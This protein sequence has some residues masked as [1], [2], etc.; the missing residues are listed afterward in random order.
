MQFEFT[1]GGHLLKLKRKVM[2]KYVDPAK[3][4]IYQPVEVTPPITANIASPVYVFSGKQQKVVQVKLK[5]FVEGSGSIS[6]KPLAG[7]NISPAKISFTNKKKN[8]EWT[9]EFV[10]SPTDNQQKVSELTAV[11]EIN[12]KASSMGLLRI[13]YD[14]IPNITLFPPAQA[15]LVN[16]DL[17][18][19]AGGKKIGYI[20]G[21][22]DL[23]PDALRQIGYDVHML[24]ENEVMNTDLS[25]YSAIITGVRTYNVNP[26]MVVEQPRLLEYVKNGGNLVVQYNTFNN[27]VKTQ[28]GP[29]PFRVVN[30][31]VTD[32]TAKV[33]FTNPNSTI[34]N[35]PN[36]ITQADFD[37]WIQERGLY[38][39]SGIDPNYQTLFEMND[40]GEAP[41]K[42]SLIYTD[43]GNGRFVYTSLDF[44]RE[45][46]AGVPGAY[47]LFINLMSAPPKQVKINK[48][49]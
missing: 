24:T 34:L 6:L 30:E 27:L 8:E 5:S 26:R 22:G 17:N 31:R 7:W 40:P 23:V 39:V 44:F 41:N 49:K 12:G 42:G 28:I 47:R 15:K 18:I 45:L 20:A 13:H 1:I 10:V 32:E 36:K 21:A 37:G 11:A 19:A 33:T 4:E 35:F 9:A 29:Y 38:F 2:Y 46:P 25:G 14:H 43:Y 48:G 16:L 3:G